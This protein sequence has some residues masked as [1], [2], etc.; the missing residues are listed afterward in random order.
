MVDPPQ[1]SLRTWGTGPQ[2]VLLVHGFSDD[3]RTWW[4]VGPAL[5][6]R[7]YRVIA[8]DLR[9]HGTSF[10]CPGYELDDMAAD[11]VRSLPAGADLAL[12]HSLG[13]MV[14]GRALDGLRPRRAVFVDPAWLRPWRDF[15]LGAVLPSTPGELGDRAEVWCADDIAVDLASNAQLDPQLGA[16][17][18]RALTR[19]EQVPPP[20]APAYGTLVLVPEHEPSLPITAHPMLEPLGYRVRTIAGVGHVMHRDDFEVFM[21]VLREEGMAA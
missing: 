10:R 9:G 3:S 18:L 11:L 17:L 7:G 4:R 5:A 13:A 21:A 16:S 1:L 6:E 12:G 14:L 15:S 8:P 20:A 2:T 19:D